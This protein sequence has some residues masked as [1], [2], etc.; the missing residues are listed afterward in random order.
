MSRLAPPSADT[1]TRAPHFSP[2]ASCLSACGRS[3]CVTSLDQHWE[4]SRGSS[5]HPGLGKA[6]PGRGAMALQSMQGR[7]QHAASG[8]LDTVPCRPEDEGRTSGDALTAAASQADAAA[9]ALVDLQVLQWLVHVLFP[10]TSTGFAR[11]TCT[12]AQVKQAQF[13]ERAQSL[14]NTIASLRCTEAELSAQLREISILLVLSQHVPGRSIAARE[15]SVSPTHAHL[16]ALVTLPCACSRNVIHVHTR[17]PGS[18]T[19]DYVAS[20][21]FC[22]GCMHTHHTSFLFA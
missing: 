4:R 20:S 14:E 11:L 1:K 21:A 12:C 6:R 18:T 10:R 19:L 5:T 17:A 16:I 13:S 9:C 8:N 22:W 2:I 3:S 7:A 15:S